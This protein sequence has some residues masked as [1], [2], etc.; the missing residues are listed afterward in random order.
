MVPLSLSEAG[1]GL[2]VAAGAATIGT[3]ATGDESSETALAAERGEDTAV[4]DVLGFATPAGGGINGGGRSLFEGELELEL[5]LEAELP[6]T[7]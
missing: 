5:E 4:N 6:E 3:A 2:R 1:G 7:E